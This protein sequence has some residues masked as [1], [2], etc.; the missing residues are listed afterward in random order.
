MKIDCHTHIGQY[1]DVRWSG[2]LA[3]WGNVTLEALT[4]FLDDL[5]VDRAVLLATY[6][7][8][9]RN[10]LPTEYVIEACR[11]YPERLIPFCVVEVREKGSEEKLAEYKD[12]GC[13]GV[14]ENTSK[15]PI[16]HKLNLKLYRRC[17]RLELPI[18]I[19]MA[20]SPS[21]EY[22]ALD[23]VKLEGL[24][25]VSKQHSDVTFIMHGPGWW[26]SISADIEDPEISYPAGEVEKPGSAVYLLENREN[27]CGDLSAA[28]GYN[29][30]ARD[31]GFARGLLERLSRKLLYGT[32]LKSLFE[33]EYSHI[34]LLEK[35]NLSSKAYENIYHKNIERLLTL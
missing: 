18:L 15:I 3:E 27:V 23:N 2:E 9:M 13:V 19:H 8:D 28:S 11:E 1:K 10:H 34:R 29:A 31:I 12:M 26:R 24:E 30:L 16:D 25:R 20:I 21:D 22:G 4:G 32:D 6:S 14:G 5:G 35:A 33:P 17:G 7:W